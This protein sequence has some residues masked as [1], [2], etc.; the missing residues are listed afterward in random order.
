MF[1]NSFCSNYSTLNHYYYVMVLLL[2][3][4]VLF[5][6][7]GESA[8]ICA[9]SLYFNEDETSNLRALARL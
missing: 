3:V 2:T 8:A 7:A 6:C 1:A 9:P 5:V 4:D